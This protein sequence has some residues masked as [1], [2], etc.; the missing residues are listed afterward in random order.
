MYEEAGRD[1]SEGVSPDDLVLGESG[2][3]EDGEDEDGEEHVV[4]SLVTSK[5]RSVGSGLAG[6]R[7]GSGVNMRH[8]SPV[9]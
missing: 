3:V 9:S 8:L 2:V 1:V 6:E 5:L 7:S 4:L